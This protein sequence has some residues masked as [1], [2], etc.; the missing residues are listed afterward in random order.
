MKKRKV[1]VGKVADLCNGQMQKIELEEGN[2][3]LARIKDKFYA[4]GANCTHYGAPLETGILNGERVVCPWHNACFNI[5]TGDQEEPPGLD[6]LSRF[7]VNIKGEDVIVELPE[8]FASQGPPEMA[9]YNPEADNRTFIIL[10]AGAAGSA[11]AETLRSSGF[12]GRLIVLSKEDILPYDRTALS[13]SYLQNHPSKE[14]L[15][16]RSQDFYEQNDIEVYTHKSV[17]QI[18]ASTKS[19]TFDDGTNLEY[20]ALLVASG[21]KARQLNIPGANLENVFTL[22]KE[23]DA[24]KIVVAAEN[25]KTAVVVG[26]SFIGMETAASLAQKEISVKVVAPGSIP[27]AKIL[28]EE[29]GDMFRQLHEQHGVGFH[30]NTKVKEIEGNTKVEAVI[31]ENGEHLK[32][33][34]VIVGIG[35]EPVTD[36]LEGIELEPEDRSIPVNEYLQATEGIY[37][38]GDVARFP[39][40]NSGE[41]TRIEHWRLAAQ[42]GRIAA[43]NMLGQQIK[44]ASVPFFWTG[45]FDVKLRYTGHAQDWDEIIFQGEIEEQKFLAFY[46]KNN[47]ILAVAGCGRDKDIAAITELMRLRKMPIPKFVKNNSTDWVKQL[48]GGVKDSSKTFTKMT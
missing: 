24:E 39:E 14:S 30:M 2:I 23:S 9:K 27:F 40:A 38:A 33:D 10:G 36:F 47:Q 17:K 43:R 5:V 8:N 16:L 19:I 34:I 4:T 6:A 37:A 31:L 3:L 13:K 29:I 41:M 7:P 45:Q 48:G 12:Q 42:H 32:A 28:G 11:A 20:D 46:V 18:D 21:S 1:Q 44:F 15:I 35:V 25:A 26:A 22:R